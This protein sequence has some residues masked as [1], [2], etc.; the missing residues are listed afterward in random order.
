MQ[1]PQYGL[2][3]IYPGNRILDTA[4]FFASTE[5]RDDVDYPVLQ[6]FQQI[7]YGKC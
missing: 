2:T 5:V 3:A 6:M 7:C 4:T 1:Q